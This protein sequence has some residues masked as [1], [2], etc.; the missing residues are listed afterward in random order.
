MQT[1]LG[2]RK[3]DSSSWVLYPPTPTRPL[4]GW[5]LRLRPGPPPYL[6]WS[7]EVNEAVPAES[8]LYP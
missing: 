2:G 1:E 8:Q 3:L 7:V 5:L 4:T 6:A